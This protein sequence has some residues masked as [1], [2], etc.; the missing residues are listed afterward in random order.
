M[1]PD[2]ACYGYINPNVFPG[3]IHPVCLGLIHTA[4]L[5][6]PFGIKQA[7]FSLLFPPHFFLSQYVPLYVIPYME[8]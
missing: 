8:L 6:L 4:K 3:L 1:L 5:P 7:D 2:V